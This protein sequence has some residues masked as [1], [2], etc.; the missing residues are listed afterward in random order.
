MI[1]TDFIELKKE[2]HTLSIPSGYDIITYNDNQDVVKNG[3]LVNNI[4]HII[5]DGN[6][7]RY[8]RLYNTPQF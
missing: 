6:V 2:I 7:I 5:I 3:Y 8:Y 1:A 4:G